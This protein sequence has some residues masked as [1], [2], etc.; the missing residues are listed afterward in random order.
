MIKDLSSIHE[1]A[2]PKKSPITTFLTQKDPRHTF[3]SPRISTVKNTPFVPKLY[4]NTTKDKISRQNQTE[5]HTNMSISKLNLLPSSFNRTSKSHLNVDLLNIQTLPE[6]PQK[7]LTT[8]DAF[9]RENSEDDL[10]LSNSQIESFLEVNNNF[11]RE[12]NQLMQNDHIVS[13]LDKDEPNARVYLPRKKLAFKSLKLKHS[14]EVIGSVDSVLELK[15]VGFKA[16]GNNIDKELVFRETNIKLISNQSLFELVD[17]N[18]KL[19]MVN[20]FV[21]GM[22]QTAKGAEQP[23]STKEILENVDIR[24]STLDTKKVEVIKGKAAKSSDF[25]RNFVINLETEEMPSLKEK[26]LLAH[27][28]SSILQGFEEFLSISVSL[29]MKAVTLFFSNCNISYFKTFLN[30]RQF[31]VK[32]LRVVF[33]NCK[34][35]NIKALLAIDNPCIRKLEVI[36]TGCEFSNIDNV[37]AVNTTGQTMANLLFE[38]NTFFQCKNVFSC[39]GPFKSLRISNNVILEILGSV[40]RVGECDSVVLDNNTIRGCITTSVASFTNCNALINN[41][42]F[43]N[44]TGVVLSIESQLDSNTPDSHKRSEI[45]I[46]RNQFK[47]N[48]NDDLAMN[49]LFTGSEVIVR[50]NMF[51]SDTSV[52]RITKLKNCAVAIEANQFRVK[53]RAI[54]Y[55]QV[56]TDVVIQNNVYHDPIPEQQNFIS[57]ISK[58]VNRAFSKSFSSISQLFKPDVSQ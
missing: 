31:K 42:T 17:S 19:R 7:H 58:S 41:N 46:T 44:N 45:H 11:F 3:H 28:D 4:S 5:S 50:Y 39:I 1:E 9:D 24:R 23:P 35:N 38:K 52:I 57:K 29:T 32:T 40:L 30:M 34:L 37:F 26:A 49:N 2:A 53:G 55:D 10:P 25:L 6:N 16:V 13:I 12:N 33:A 18:V 56:E 36:A 8:F 14:V 15:E 51:E 21:K 47:A 48:H 20:C 22:A 27:F 43:T 54:I